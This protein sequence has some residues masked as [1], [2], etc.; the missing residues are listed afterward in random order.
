VLDR[1]C[2]RFY[3]NAGLVLVLL[4]ALGW[5]IRRIKRARHH[6]MKNGV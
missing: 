4:V 2:R 3:L 1:P 6:I 5:G